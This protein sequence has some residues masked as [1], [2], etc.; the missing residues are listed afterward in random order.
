MS[1]ALLIAMINF[2]TR[3][4]LDAAIAFLESK[5]AT[6]DDAISAL[7]KASEKSLDQYILEAK[8]TNQ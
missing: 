8:S 6:I 5:G 7:K 1:E 4:G 2:A 3:F